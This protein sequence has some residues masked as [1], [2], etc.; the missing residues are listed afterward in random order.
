MIDD[1]VAAL[2][3][4]HPWV[5]GNEFSDEVGKRYMPLVSEWLKLKYCNRKGTT[6]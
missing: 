5:S 3:Q 4:A 6:L 2:Q 1:P